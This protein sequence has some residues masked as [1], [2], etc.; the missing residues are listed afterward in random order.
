[1]ADGRGLDPQHAG[2]LGGGEPLFITG[3][4][5]GKPAPDRLGHRVRHKSRPED[6]RVD[7]Q[8]DQAAAHGLF[9]SAELSRKRGDADD[10]CHP[11]SVT[12]WH[13]GK[14][15]VLPGQASLSVKKASSPGGLR[16]LGAL[17]APVVM[18]SQAWAGV[19]SERRIA[20]N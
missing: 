10:F 13:M 3:N 9:I 12:A 18:V 15:R 17:R 2:N 5:L 20:L 6:E 1:M 7:P 16:G 4:Q 19:Q 8:F 14:G 11:N